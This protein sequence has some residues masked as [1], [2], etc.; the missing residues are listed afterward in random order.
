MEGRHIHPVVLCGRAGTRLW[1]L[2]RALYPKQFLALASERTLFQD[3]ILRTADSTRFAQPVVVGNE[4]HRFMRA[5]G[6]PRFVMITWRCVAATSSRMA[7]HPC[8]KTPAGTAFGFMDMVH[9]H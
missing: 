8:L 6:W 2:S 3:T 1:P 5:T 4:Y 9:G 7:R